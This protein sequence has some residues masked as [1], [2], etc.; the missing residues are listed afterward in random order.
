MIGVEVDRDGCDLVP[1]DGAG[2][3]LD[4]LATTAPWS[5]ACAL[6]QNVV[7]QAAEMKRS[8]LTKVLVMM[9]SFSRVR[10]EG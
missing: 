4:A 6:V 10:V 8:S 2:E 9:C 3:L 7:T 5:T 1:L